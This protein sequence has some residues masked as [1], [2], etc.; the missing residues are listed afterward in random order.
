MALLEE[1]CSDPLTWDFKEGT[2]VSIMESHFMPTLRMSSTN[3]EYSFYLTVPKTEQVMFF[4]KDENEVD[5]SEL[6]LGSRVTLL[7]LLD[8]I[9]SRNHFYHMKF[10]LEQAKVRSPEKEV[11]ED[12]KEESNDKEKIQEE[13]KEEIKL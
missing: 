7:L 13:T 1:I 9:E 11:E 10:I 4:D 6:K 12:S 2:P 8:G 5:M 3:F